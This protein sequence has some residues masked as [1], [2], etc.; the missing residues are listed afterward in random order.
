MN[1]AL[2]HTVAKAVCSMYIFNYIKAKLLLVL[3][4]L[5]WYG[6]VRLLHEW[7]RLV[8]VVWLI[9]IDKK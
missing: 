5:P 3:R 7:K 1:I 6:H 4:V 8:E 2:L 9:K